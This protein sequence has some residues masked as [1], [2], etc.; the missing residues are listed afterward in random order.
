MKKKS[1][2]NDD[3]LNIVN[4]I[5]EKDKTIEDSKK[6]YPDKIRNS[7]EALLKYIEEND[8][9]VLKTGF[10][11]KW[12]YLTEKLAFPYGFLN[13]IED[14]Q[15]PVH[16]LKKE[17]FFSKL[18]NHYSDDEKIEKTK[19]IIKRFNIENGEKLTEIY[20]KIDVLLHTCVF[21][22]YV[23]VSVNEFGINPPYCVSLPGCTWQCGLKYTG[24]NLQT[25]QGKDM[26][27]II[28]NNFR[29][30]IGSVMGDR[31]VKSVDNKKIK[32]ADANNLYGHSISQPLP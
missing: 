5:K 22:N 32:S 23:K 1:V 28:E 3:I 31:Y 9:K 6:D 14:Y 26:S 18:K 11:D 4:E 25:L 30:G 13:C 17:D 16:N 29:G 7:E 21:E 8:P 24:M 12:K 20:S 15:K 19:V 10:P 2:D 27:L